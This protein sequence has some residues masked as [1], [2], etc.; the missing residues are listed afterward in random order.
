LQN[1]NVAGDNYVN[2]PTLLQRAS[3]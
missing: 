3:T 1:C 2:V